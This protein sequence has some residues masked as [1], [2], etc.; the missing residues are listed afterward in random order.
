MILQRHKIT[1]IFLIYNI[2]FKKNFVRNYIFYQLTDEVIICLLIK[3]HIISKLQK[4]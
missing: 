1:I 4:I 2:I 3:Y